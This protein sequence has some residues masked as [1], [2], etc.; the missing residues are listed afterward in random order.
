VHWK[1]SASILA[2]LTIDLWWCRCVCWV[3]SIQIV[4][5]WLTRA[6]CSGMWTS[7]TSRTRAMRRCQLPPKEECLWNILKCWRLHQFHKEWTW[8]PKHTGTML[9]SPF[10]LKELSCNACTTWGLFEFIPRHNIFDLVWYRKLVW[11]R[12]VT[13]FNLALPNVYFQHHF[14]NIKF[15]NH[16]E[17]YVFLWSRNHKFGGA[18]I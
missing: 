17:N 7:A 15:S 14:C 10:V 5:C 11:H 13:L 1:C 16:T 6:M 4:W 9:T 18:W 2:F 8:L 12:W 3:W